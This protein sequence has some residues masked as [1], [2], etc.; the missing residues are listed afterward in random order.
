[1]I[2]EGTLFDGARAI[3]RPVRIDADADR[4]AISGAEESAQH[5][6]RDQIAADPPIPGVPR[7]LRLPGGAMVETA[8]RAAVETLW[9]TRQVVARAAF[10][11]ESRLAFALLALVL[12]AAVVWAIVTYALPLAANPASRLISPQVQKIIGERTLATLDRIALKP[13]ELPVQRQRHLVVYVQRFMADEPDAQ[14]YRLEFR[15]AG[16]A[17]A[18]A[19][20]GGIIIVTDEMV[21]SLKRDD[22]FLAVVAHEVGH[23]HAR[24]A[25][26]M[27]LQDSGLAVLM[28]ALAGDAVG[29]TVLVAAVPSVLLR[30]HYSRQFETEAD[31]YAF[32][33]LKRRGFSPQLFADV[34][35][36][37]QATTSS[38]DNGRVLRYL[39]SHPLT[40]ERIRRAEEQR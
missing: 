8:D 26:R 6:R 14:G 24:H 11:L 5:L 35:R 3:G 17:N 15:K 32:A 18:F 30:S 19:L 25:M 28:T 20:P 16:V 7:L 23:V 36:Q 21:R 38:T 40:E 39:S 22:E 31:D 1:M 27:V 4:V 37:L 9:P 33:L 13:S 2:F 29:V 34:L 10:T 12:S